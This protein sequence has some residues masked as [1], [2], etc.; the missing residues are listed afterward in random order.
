[1]AEREVDNGWRLRQMEV[2]IVEMSIHR[3][4]YIGGCGMRECSE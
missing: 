2:E 3:R 4:I 1:M